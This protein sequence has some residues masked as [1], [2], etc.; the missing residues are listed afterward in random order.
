MKNLTLA[1]GLLSVL[2]AGVAAQDAAPGDRIEITFPNGGSVMGTVIAPPK[3][4]PAASVT[5]D[6]A[7]EYPGLRGTITVP[8]RDIQ[9][10]RK[11]RILKEARMCD[12]T[13]PPIV[14][15]PVKPAA[16]PPVVAT[17]EPPK[18]VSPPDDKAAEELRKAREMYARFPSPDWSP[19][20]YTMIRVKQYRGQLPTPMEREFA[21]G[22]ELWVKGRDAA[23][24]K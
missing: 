22:F 15:E 21:Q 23:G 9:S 24:K 10:V 4:A 2:A 20:R 12:L 5:L 13:N 11:L 7:S 16:P 18:P 14:Q 19:E 8:N 6:L 17:P 3:G 1:L